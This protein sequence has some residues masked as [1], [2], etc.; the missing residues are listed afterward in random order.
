MTRTNR[1]R[2]RRGFTLVEVLTVFVIIGIL[3]AILLPAI[4]NAVGAAKN[5]AVLAEMNQLG[6]ALQTFKN[7]YG[8]FPPSRIM[9]C[10][11]TY[12]NILST[13][14]LDSPPSSWYATSATGVPNYPDPTTYDDLTYGQLAVRS[15]GYLRKF[16]PRAQALD[17]TSGASAQSAFQTN[18]TLALSTSPT[19]WP[20]F[21]GDGVCQ[22]NPI[23]LQGG[24]CLA[25]FLGGLP[26]TAS[27]STGF[28]TGGAMTGF[29]KSPQYPFVNDAIPNQLSTTIAVP[30]DTAL[31]EFKGDRLV[32]D[33]LDSI[34]GYVDSLGSVSSGNATYYAYFS[35]YGATGANGGYDPNDNNSAAEIGILATFRTTF[36]AGPSGSQANSVQSP[37]PN[38]YTSSFPVPTSTGTSSPPAS[39]LNPQTFQIISA[40][41]DRVFGF[42]GQYIANAPG[43]RL[44]VNSLMSGTYQGSPLSDRAFEK[45]NLTNFNGSK[46]E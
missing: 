7:R 19:Y 4:G 6:Q 46:L 5:A 18:S 40:G 33:D 13:A 38:P 11:N 26:S 31:F 28:S 17:S 15:L 39:Y 36:L 1:S 24:E 16:W 22:A 27:V 30:R 44:P 20:D 29:S 35:A 3:T 12:Y 2:R 32:D 10:E 23:L 8:E 34:P 25:F 45:D 21:N 14:Q 43:S 41:S 37:A 42:G 9:L